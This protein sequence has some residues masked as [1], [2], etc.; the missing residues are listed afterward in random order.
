MDKDIMKRLLKAADIPI[1]DYLVLEEDEADTCSF[2]EVEK[3]LGMPV[4]VKPANLGSSV[5]ISR[6]TTAKE[7]EI[8]I[9]TAFMSSLRTP[10]QSKITAFIL[11]QSSMDRLPCRSA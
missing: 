7:F 2:S 11:W 1:A 3:L 5:G 8:A 4:F 9:K 6:V 10:D